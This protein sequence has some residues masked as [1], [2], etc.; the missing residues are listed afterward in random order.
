[1]SP[2]YDDWMEKVSLN[3]GPIQPLLLDDSVTEIMVNRFDKIFVE[4]EGQLQATPMKFASEKAVVDLIYGIAANVGREITNAHPAMD[5]YLPDGSRVNAS[6]PPMVPNGATITI[7]KFRKT[8]YGLADF[9]KLGSLSDKAAYFLHACVISR[10]NIVVS[11]GT[12]TGKTTFLNALSAVIPESERIITIED[13]SEL[14]LQHE[15]WV[16]LESVYRPN[17]ITI[18]TRDC[19]INSLRMR[20]DR[21]LVGE[22]RRDETFEML[23]AMN[24]GHDGSM[25]TVHSNSSRDCL[26][27]LESLILT[28]NVEMPLPAL[29]KQM[30]SAIDLIVQLKRNKNGQRIVHEIVEVT[31]MEQTTI[32]AQVLFSREKKKIVG[33]AT[34]PPGLAGE[35]LL[36]SGIVPTFLERFSDAGIQFPPNFFDANTSVT[37]R[38]D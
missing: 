35:P 27:R 25:T 8:P 6:L 15:N 24:T 1:M 2:C 16:R 4:R 33:P 26:S 18:S 29:R 10:L 11:G 17:G 22:C 36:A 19:L 31:G 12:G 38:P 5:G 7:R 28:S 20:P 34:T 9:V 13:V 23:Q 21:I 37:Y 3:F 30:A 14:N 32:T